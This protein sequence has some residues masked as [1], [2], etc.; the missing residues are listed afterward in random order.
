VKDVYGREVGKLVG[1][2]MGLDGKVS[3]IGVNEASGKFTQ[4]SSGRIRKGE[5]EYVVI[6]DWKAEA[7][8]FVRERDSLRKRLLVLEELS[9]I[10]GSHSTSSVDLE[11][12][13][14]RV[15]AGHAKLK[16]KIEGRLA[17]LS[18]WDD[19]LDEFIAMAKIQRTTAEIDE[20]AFRSTTDYGRFALSCDLQ[21]REELRRALVYLENIEEPVPELATEMTVEIQEEREAHSDPLEKAIPAIQVAAHRSQQ[22]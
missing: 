15:M 6:P 7:Q 22:A 13:L 8:S 4:Y 3:S 16:H 9:H 17:E 19:E 21:E 1:V 18:R 12:Q 10:K 20:E 11:C 5:S 2:V 14:E